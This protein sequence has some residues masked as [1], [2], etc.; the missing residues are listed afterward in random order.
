[1]VPYIVAENP[2]LGANETITL[3]RKMMNG[4]KW[5]LFTLELSFFGMG[6]SGSFYRLDR[7]Y[8][9]YKTLQRNYHV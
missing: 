3:S 1:M 8:T 4:H 6:N 9:Y 7:E 2:E 5:E